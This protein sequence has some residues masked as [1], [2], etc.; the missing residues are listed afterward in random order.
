MP[1]WEKE[2]ACEKIDGEC[3]VSSKALSCRVKA[4]NQE[5]VGT[6]LVLII[7]HDRKLFGMKTTTSD[8]PL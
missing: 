7:L 1:Q 6:G 2:K 4:Y 8:L 5:L 3:F